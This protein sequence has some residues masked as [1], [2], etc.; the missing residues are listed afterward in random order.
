[1]DRSADQTDASQGNGNTQEA[2][3]PIYIALAGNPNSGKTTVFNALT[4][5]RAHVGNYPGVTVERREGR[6]RV[7]GW[8]IQVLDLPGCY[9]LIPHSLDERISRDVLLHRRP[10]IPP[11]SL[12]VVVVDA[13]SLERQLYLVT[14]VLELGIPTVVALNM[15]DLA[16]Q[17]GL[18]IDVDRLSRRLGCPI[19]P[20]VA[21]RRSGIKDLIQTIL[22]ELDHPSPRSVE[23]LPLAQLPSPWKEEVDR[24]ARLIIRLR[25]DRHRFARV[26]A[27]LALIDHRNRE[28]YITFYG[29]EFAQ[30]LGEGLSR[31]SEKD[32]DGHTLLVRLRYEWIGRLIQ[33]VVVRQFRQEQSWTDRLDR[34]LTHPVFG[35]IILVLVML[36]FFQA[37]FSL[38]ELPQRLLETWVDQVGGW[39]ASLLPPG[40][41]RDL[42]VRGVFGGAGSVLVFVPQIA[43]LFFL[44]G[45]MEDSGYMARAAFLMDRLMSKV[46]LHG[47]SFIPLLSSYA[48]AVPGILATRTIEDVRTRL[49]TIFVAP[50]MTCPARLPVFTLLIDATIPNKRILGFLGLQG[51]VLAG[52]YFLGLVGAL[53]TAW[54]FKKTLLRKHKSFLILELPTYRRPLLRVVLVHTWARVKLFLRKVGTVI[55]GASVVLWFLANYPVDRTARAQY[56]QQ[57]RVLEARMVSLDTSDPQHLQWEGKLHA[58]DREFARRRLE[59]SLIGRLGRWMEPALRPLGFDWKI[60]IGILSSFAARELFVSTMALVYGVEYNEEEG[61]QQLAHVLAQVRGPNGELIYDVTTGLALMIFYV[62]AL[63]CISTVIVVRRET[64]SWRWPL[65]QWVYMTG[66]AY[67]AAMVVYVFG[68][69]L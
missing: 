36:I 65:F 25:P 62:F 58:L 2:K 64:N 37:I 22:Q 67:L 54:L 56:F 38:A 18:K 5:L 66:L 57:R 47:K 3:R 13:S 49:V 41:F 11:I 69:I 59:N 63:Q 20:L 40:E 10:E 55:L 52:M 8:Q 7:R 34:V 26:E 53:V 19:I 50:F 31:L 61:L 44:L 68:Q 16:E 4:G 28:D 9:S 24:L 29:S 43:I 33:E 6:M 1:M 45:I 51:L 30:V 48:C 21:N 23:T 14:Q 39:V 60:G 46:G 42:I 32:A 12:V 35:T 27:L 15:M 17:A